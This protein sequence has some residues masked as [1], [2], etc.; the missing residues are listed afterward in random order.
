MAL[1][2][3]PAPA[4]QGSALRRIPVSLVRTHP[5]IHTVSHLHAGLCAHCE[6]I[7]VPFG[8]PPPCNDVVDVPVFG[9][10]HRPSI[11]FC[12]LIYF[13]DEGTQKQV[14][15]FG[16]VKGHIRVYGPTVAFAKEL[17]GTRE[18]TITSYTRSNCNGKQKGRQ[19]TPET[20]FASWLAVCHNLRVCQSRTNESHHPSILPPLDSFSRLARCTRTQPD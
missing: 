6:P 3:Q 10:A 8:S 18:A 16:G 9:T 4:R 15:L 2:T 13:H 1:L 14:D 7:G 5:S 19:T 11:L 12:F 20:G 17:P